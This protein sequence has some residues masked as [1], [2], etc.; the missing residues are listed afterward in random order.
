M[1]VINLNGK[2][3]QFFGL[4]FTYL[5]F[6]LQ[7]QPNTAAGCLYLWR[8][9]PSMVRIILKPITMYYYKQKYILSRLSKIKFYSVQISQIAKRY[10]QR[11]G[12]IATDNI[13]PS[14]TTSNWMLI[15]PHLPLLPYLCF[16]RGALKMFTL[17]PLLWKDPHSPKSK[18]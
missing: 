16:F 2:Y 9:L 15:I 6:W 5:L 10:T 18:F 7:S 11:I 3:C 13:S 14:I 8:T 1:L 12:E 17:V 4:I